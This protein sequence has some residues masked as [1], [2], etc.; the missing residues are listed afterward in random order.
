LAESLGTD[1]W[2]AYQNGK[3]IVEF[4]GKRITDA[5]APVDWSQGI[6]NFKRK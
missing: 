4:N 3:F 1:D 5:E 6:V 2:E